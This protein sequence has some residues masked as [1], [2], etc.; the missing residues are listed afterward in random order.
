[1][2]KISFTL[3][4]FLL[5]PLVVLSLSAQVRADKHPRVTL[6]QGG[7]AQIVITETVKL[8][9]GENEIVKKFSGSMIKDTLF[10]DSD[11]AQLKRADFHTSKPS[12]SGLLSEYMG[13]NITVASTV[14]NQ[15]KTVTGKLVTLVNGN[16]LIQVDDQETV[17]VKNPVEYYLNNR[18]LPDFQDLLELTLEAQTRGEM[19]L[20]YGYQLQG[21]SWEPKYTGFLDEG[22]ETLEIRGVAHVTNSSTEEFRSASVNLIAGAPNREEDAY[23]QFN[24]AR[25]A[26]AKAPSAPEEVF[27]YYKYPIDFPVR[28][29][30]GGEFQIPFLHKGPVD[31]ERE[32]YYIPSSREAVQIAME[33]ENTEE[34]GLG[35]PMAAGTLRIYE[36]VEKTF[37]GADRLQNTAVG[38]E[39]ELSLGAAFD[40]KGSRARKKHKKIADSTW[41][42]EIEIELTNRKD[43][44]ITVNAVESPSGS[45]EIL[46][47]SHSYEV[48]S[49]NRIQ[50]TTEVGSDSSTK[51]R[52]RVRYEY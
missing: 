22:E 40:V 7:P 4:A 42:D 10:V 24:L 16:P 14:G 15:M 33:I 8:Y 6:Y 49:S 44:K 23:P 9:K 2:K 51:I 12:E 30:A 1:M 37:L 39:I 21:L 20:T 3:L 48:L 47:S 38:E 27:E 25:T 26:A 34:S 19:E 13:E 29:L 41:E 52:Y 36:D 11:K 50:F 32:Y 46:E 5:I 17:L 31:F 45:W 28:V 18:G 35:L 43:E